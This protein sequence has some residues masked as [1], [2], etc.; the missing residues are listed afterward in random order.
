MCELVGENVRA[1][2]VAMSGK[3]RR[4]ES[5]EAASSAV[6]KRAVTAKIVE[7]WKTDHDRELDT[8]TWLTYKMADRNHV[9]SM[10]CS[11]CT[12]FR[13]KIQGMRNFS[14]AFIEG[15]QNLRA[16]SFKDQAAS[17]MH[18]RL[19]MLLKK[20]QSTDVCQYALI[21]MYMYK[22]HQVLEKTL[23]L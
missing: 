22:I 17:E 10:S 5:V 12:C 9:D 11:V 23:L 3:K 15:T 19:W 18:K 1:L 4:A 16:S 2:S 6:K 21:D 8:L 13:A 7:K 20:E 14:Q